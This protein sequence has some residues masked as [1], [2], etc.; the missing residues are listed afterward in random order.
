MEAIVLFA[1]VAALILLAVTSMRYG[2]D[3]R[4]GFTSKER[5]PASHEIVRAE[6][7]ATR[8]GRPSVWAFTLPV[9]RKCVSASCG[10]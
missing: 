1:A 2:V 6:S 4:E 10:A 8:R 3:S 9:P 7:S 5:E